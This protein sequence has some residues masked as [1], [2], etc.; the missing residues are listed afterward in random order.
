[1][2]PTGNDTA[3]GVWVIILAY[4]VFMPGAAFDGTMLAAQPAQSLRLRMGFAF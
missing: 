1:M 2:D 4:G 3:A